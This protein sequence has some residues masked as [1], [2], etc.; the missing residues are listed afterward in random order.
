VRRATGEVMHAS[1]RRGF[2]TSRLNLP[3]GPA[4]G[5]AALEECENGESDSDGAPVV[6]CQEV[7]GF[8]RPLTTERRDRSKHAPGLLVPGVFNKYTFCRPGIQVL[9]H[10]ERLLCERSAS[11]D[12]QNRGI[13]LPAPE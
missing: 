2:E 11:P 12:S 10:L 6:G 4:T 13:R 8:L 7:S 5:S 3:A 1:G 9:T